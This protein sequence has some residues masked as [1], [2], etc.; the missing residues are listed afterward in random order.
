MSATGR[1]DRRVPPSP[2]LALTPGTL[3]GQG[4]ER[5]IEPAVRSLLARVESAL[6]AGL[7]ALLLREPG[8]SD[9]ALLDLARR[10]RA[11]L[12]P[13][14]WLAVHDRVH[15]ALAAG[16]DAAHLGFRSLP[17]GAARRAAGPAL[18]LG[19]SAHLHDVQD[20]QRMQHLQHDQDPRDRQVLQPEEAAGGRAAWDEADYLVF[21]PVRAT[22]SKQGLLAPTGFEALA[23]ACRAAAAP[24]WAIGGLGAE[25][26]AAALGAGARGVAALRGVLGA[27]DPAGATRSYLDAL[28]E[29]RGGGATG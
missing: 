3:G 22:P 27:P 16:A 26:A 20:L 25:D 10:L 7:R 19:F 23:E 13:D 18:A 14:G 21:G 28:A 4:S 1:A 8:L 5:E 6:E 12:G 2:L 15:V 29:A 17:L 11:L 24:V 9:R